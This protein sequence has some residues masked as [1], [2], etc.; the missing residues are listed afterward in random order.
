[1][2]RI[3]EWILDESKWLA[4]S[5]VLA[6]AVVLATFLRHS[7]RPSRRLAVVRAM[8]VF[9]GC[10]IGT[11]ACGHLL[12]VTVEASRGTLEGS[13]AL[14][15]ALGIALATPSWWLVL[16]AARL[17]GDDE[18]TRRRTVAINLWLGATLIALGV[19][20]APLAVPAAL[21]VAYR[22]HSRPVV[23]RAL[24]T[25]IVAANLLLFVGSLVFFAS[26]QSF[27]QFSD[28]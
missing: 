24:V 20:N 19:H 5:M 8:N 9:Y 13:P 10:T 15:Y 26:G 11:M 14:L 6:G 22:L 27:E 28:M 3:T 7:P 17:A 23:G 1:M 4:L 12:A 18:R 16:H 21:N 25:A 2:D